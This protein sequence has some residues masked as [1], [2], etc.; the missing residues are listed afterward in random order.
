MKYAYDE[1][2]IA[3]FL[4]TLYR[5]KILKDFK[6]LDKMI[7]ELQIR[8]FASEKGITVQKLL[9]DLKL[10]HLYPKK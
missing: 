2:Y 1:Q 4:R 3:D 9:S 5:L 10:N 7:D 8:L 6:I